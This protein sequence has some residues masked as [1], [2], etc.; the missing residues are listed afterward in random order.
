MRPDIL[1]ASG[2][3]FSFTD[4]LNSFYTLDDIA[5]ALSHICRFGGHV[6]RF[7]S[8]AQHCVMASYITPASD[9][10]AALMHDA[11]EAFVGDMPSPLKQLLPDYKA[12]EARIEAA[13]FDCFDISLPLP[14][15]VKEA[16]LI[17]LATEQRDLMPPHDD[18]WATIKGVT[19]LP[20][21]ILPW[22]ALTAKQ[23]FI[24]RFNALTR[25]RR[26]A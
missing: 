14:A 25:N 18:E 16:D 8:V 21:P 15:S 24:D 26:T 12:L 19:P 1:T 17:M 6:R 7:Y 13:V 22:D 2:H 10:L 9:A 4:P 23:S 20:F 3:Y 11:P 5:H